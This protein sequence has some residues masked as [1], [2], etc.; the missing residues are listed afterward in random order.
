PSA[1]TTPACIS[2][3]YVV[4]NLSR[5]KP[6]GFLSHTEPQA[7]KSALLE[8]VPRWSVGAR[9]GGMQRAAAL[10]AEEHRERARRDALAPVR[11]SD[12]VPDAVASI[13]L[14]ARDAA[15]HLGPAHAI[16]LDHA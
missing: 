10:V 7:P 14:K 8:N 6:I 5:Q 2:L 15:D 11:P 1:G 12:P 4:R 3:Q 13:H 16:D 9:R